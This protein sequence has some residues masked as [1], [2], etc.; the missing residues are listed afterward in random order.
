MEGK[1]ISAN[2]NI[3]PLFVLLYYSN[4]WSEFIFFSLNL[5]ESP[6]LQT[7]SIEIG[8]FFALLAKNHFFCKL[9]NINSAWKK[10]YDL[11]IFPRDLWYMVFSMHA[12]L[13]ISTFMAFVWRLWSQGPLKSKNPLIFFLKTEKYQILAI[14]ICMQDQTNQDWNW[15]IK[16]HEFH[17]FFSAPGF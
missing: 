1:L 3:C 12:F 10:K 15:L 6:G 11:S 14:G 2:A 7:K 8:V 17:G 9:L 5:M 16:W 4:E 13:R